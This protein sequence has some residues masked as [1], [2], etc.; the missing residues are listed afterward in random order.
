MNELEPEPGVSQVSP[1]LCSSHHTI[2]GGVGAQGAG[3]EALKVRS[4]LVSFLLCV[5]ILLVNDSLHPS[6]E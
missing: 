1:V 6:G 2:I 5:H 3:A 4:K